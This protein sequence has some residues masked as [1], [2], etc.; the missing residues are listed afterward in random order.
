ML[1]LDSIDLFVLF[2]DTGDHG[3]VLVCVLL[4]LHQQRGAERWRGAGHRTE[5]AG[6]TASG[7]VL[8]A[9]ELARGGEPAPRCVLILLQNHLRR[10]EP[11]GVR[12]HE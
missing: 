11:C 8:Q 6:C 4:D 5:A 10:C 2:F 9:G 1:L 12:G 7:A 3:D